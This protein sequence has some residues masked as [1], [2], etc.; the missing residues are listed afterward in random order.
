MSCDVI[1][2]GNPLP[3]QAL[4]KRILA[5]RLRK[6]WNLSVLASKAGVSRTT[7]F[8]MERGAV[9]SP[10]AATLHRLAVA[11]EIPVAQLNPQEQSPAE[12]RSNGLMPPE[13]STKTELD[14]R[15]NPYVDVLVQQ[16][17][18]V[19]AGFTPD[20]WGELYN[21]FGNAAAMNEEN[22]LQAATNIAHKRET[23]R[24]LSMLLETH[25][26]A[27]AAAMI[28]GLFDLAHLSHAS[29]SPLPAGGD[30]S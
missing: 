4:G 19:F 28:N 8:Q 21:S 6:G 17:P 2:M 22:L 1:T 27:A 10:R 24:R 11:L 18:Q 14:R 13:L 26:A 29:E 9:P 16:F 23:L 7:L 15:V 25:L 30:A 12:W 3:Q 20:D 5:A